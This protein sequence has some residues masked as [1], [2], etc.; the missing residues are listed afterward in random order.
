MVILLP[1]PAPRA[2]I[3]RADEPQQRV[4]GR[5]RRRDI[6]GGEHRFLRRLEVRPVVDRRFVAQ[7]LDRQVGH[8]LVP[9]AHDEALARRGLADD[10]E[11]EAPFAKDRLGLALLLGPEHHEHALLAL[12]QHH[13]VGAHAALAA[14]HGIEIERNAEAAFGA[15]LDRGAGEP[16]R[17]HVLNG[18]HAVLRHDFQTGLEEELFREGIADL[19]GRA[20]FLGCITELGGRHCRAVDAVAAGFGAEI[21]DR[22]ADPGG[23]GVEDS[24]AARQPDGH[25]IDEAVAV[26]AGVETH[27]AAYRRHAEGIAVAADAGD[28]AGDKSARLRIRRRAEGERVEAGDRPRAHGEDV[29]QDATNPG[30]GALIGLDIARV[31]VAL[32]LEHDGEPITD[33]DDAGVLAWPLDHPRRFR[34]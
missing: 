12:G 10:G 6:G 32:H 13:L 23:G 15:H 26:V 17:A 18:D 27:A 19:H 11:I 7:L 16:R 34:R 28:H 20:L 4:R 8:D 3:G 5:N 25:R 29:A 24:V 1:D 22:H 2:Q 21:D 9:V 30:R 31:V 14:R 33:I